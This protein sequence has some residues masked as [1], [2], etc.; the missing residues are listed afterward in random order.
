MGLG[1][2]T[3]KLEHPSHSIISRAHAFALTYVG[4]D[5]DHLSGFSTVVTSFLSILSSLAGGHYQRPL[6]VG[7][8]PFLALYQTNC[9]NAGLKGGG[10]REELSIW[11]NQV[12][13]S[14]NDLIM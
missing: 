4:V 8:I 13:V 2:K 10:R 6:K 9:T 3:L 11:F 12:P 5:L 7:A 14:R 1:R